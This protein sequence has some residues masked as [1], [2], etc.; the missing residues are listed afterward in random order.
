MCLS[1]VLQLPNKSQ[2]CSKYLHRWYF[3]LGPIS[4]FTEVWELLM[5]NGRV[6]KEDKA[7]QVIC[8][9]AIVLVTTQ[10]S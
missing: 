3:D 9:I 2:V 10:W 6:L 7:G 4:L 8:D 1:S 5:I